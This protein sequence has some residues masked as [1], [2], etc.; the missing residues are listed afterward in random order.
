MAVRQSVRSPPLSSSV[1]RYDTD[2][3]GISLRRSTKE[4]LFAI[5]V[6]GFETTSVRG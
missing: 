3:T 2:L 5:G 4:A 1:A 6:S